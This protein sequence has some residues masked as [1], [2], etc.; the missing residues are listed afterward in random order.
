MTIGRRQ[1]YVGKLSFGAF[2]SSSLDRIIVATESNV[3]AAIS[4][5]SGDIL[6]RQVLETGPRGDIKLLHVPSQGNGV[7][8]QSGGRYNRAFDVITVTGV[9]PAMVRGWN[10]NTGTLE[11]EWSL[12][13][14][15]PDRA[16][17]AVW[18]LHEGTLY[19][20]V[21]VVG[22]HL[23][24][25]GY[26]ATTGQQT[27]AAT[28]RIT[29]AWIKDGRCTLSG[30]FYACA[31]DEQLLAIDLLAE[32]PQIIVKPLEVLASSA[33]KPLPGTPAIIQDNRLY[34]LTSDHKTQLSPED[35]LLVD[36]SVLEGEPLLLH[37]TT[38]RP[39]NTLSL[40]AQKLRDN[41]PYEALDFSA[42]YP[43]TLGAP[44]LV[45]I[46]C[47]TSAGGGKQLACRVLI[48]SED[49]AITLVQQGKIKWT[50]EEALADV[51]TADFLDLTLSDAEGAIEE[52]L[53]NKNGELNGVL[54]LNF[55]LYKSNKSFSPQSFIAQRTV[56]WNVSFSN[57][58][59]NLFG[60][61]CFA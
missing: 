28:T 31:I 54:Y 45:A 1:H 46:R 34:S 55:K 18:F 59:V 41:T 56:V 5:K 58:V 60:T 57:E 50:R 16:E 21:P 39:K 25:T 61:F 24:L 22:S 23:E 12:V 40:A 14:V 6:W 17:G 13:P 49:G 44:Q 36:D 19:Q 26:V 8:Q 10:S 35:S 3:L 11:W 2:D 38:N 20:V 4:A 47:K 27:R 29:A 32:N 15:N 48:A 51:E 43:E 53:N 33:P 9:S 42:E 52:E 30:S 37:A 7:V